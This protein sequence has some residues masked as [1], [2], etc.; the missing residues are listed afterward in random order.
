M[1]NEITITSSLRVSK[2]GMTFAPASATFQATQ[3]GESFTVDL[4][5]VTTAAAQV[6]ITGSLGGWLMVKNLD[7]TNFIDFGPWVSATLHKLIRIGPS[8][9]FVFRSTPS[10]SYGAQ[11]DTA[12]CNIQIAAIEA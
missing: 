11:A 9:A 1:A 12:S 10:I 6:T 8:Q 7:A 3:T 4:Y 5:T 2:N